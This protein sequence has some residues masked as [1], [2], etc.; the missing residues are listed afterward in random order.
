MK[1]WIGLGLFVIALACGG[2]P[3]G[4]TAGVNGPLS[5]HIVLGVDGWAIDLSTG[6]QRRIA[7]LEPWDERE[8]YLG[9]ATVYAVPRSY[10]GSE[11]LETVHS[12]M[13]PKGPLVTYNCLN[14][15]SGGSFGKLLPVRGRLLGAA[16]LS[17]DGTRI[18]LLRQFGA[19]SDDLYL[20]LLDREGTVVS[21]EVIFGRATSVGFTW[22]N[23]GRVVYA[24]RNELHVA[25]PDLSQDVVLRAF[26]EAVREP[27]VSPDGRRIAFVRVSEGNLAASHGTVWTMKLDG[28]DLARVVTGHDERDPIVAHP[29]WSPDGR[30][31]L[32]EH[33]DV[34]GATGHNPGLPGAL[35]AVPAGARDVVLG[36]DD[37]ARVV[38]CRRRLRNG[39]GELDTK[40]RSKGLVSWVNAL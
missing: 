32:V 8:E 6:E 3:Q 38:R 30:W 7:G 40:C 2:L 29:T 17:P 10:D 37:R 24:L 16:R 36:A 19:S 12:C 15:W 14:T 4:A 5:G 39:P 23:D 18:A 34:T 1:H 27:V 26:E 25:G 31:L 22:T 21:S 13:S 28:S 20:Q 33:G 11:I 35:Y 9:T